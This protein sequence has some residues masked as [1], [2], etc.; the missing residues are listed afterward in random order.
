M[1]TQDAMDDL[2]MAINAAF[3]KEGIKLLP[4]VQTG[5]ATNTEKEKQDNNDGT[6]NNKPPVQTVAP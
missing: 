1:F 6:V 2:R 4:P 3:P 5:L